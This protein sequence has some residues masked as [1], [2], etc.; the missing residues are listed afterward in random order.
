MGALKEL[1]RLWHSYTNI[2]CNT[3]LNQ[4]HAPEKWAL[5]CQVKKGLIQTELIP[6]DTGAFAL[7]LRAE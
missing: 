2:V 3:G 5:R 4:V 1:L 7:R 6:S